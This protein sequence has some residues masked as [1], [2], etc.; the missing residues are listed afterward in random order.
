V[1]LPAGQSLS[2]IVTAPVRPDASGGIVEY[3]VS[4]SLGAD[5]VVAK[6]RDSDL[7]VLLRNG[8]EPEEAGGPN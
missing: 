2:W 4:A 6:A 7:L 3:A 5:G 1:A 8:F